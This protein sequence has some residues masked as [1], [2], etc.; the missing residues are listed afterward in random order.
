MT[1]RKTTDHH[2]RQHMAERNENEFTSARQWCRRPVTHS[3]M[4]QMD[5]RDVMCEFSEYHV[6]WPVL[7]RRRRQ[8]GEWGIV[9]LYL[10]ASYIISSV[11]RANQLTHCL[12]LRFDGHLVNGLRSSH[13]PR[14]HLLMIIALN[15]TFCVSLRICIL[16][17]K[18]GHTSRTRVDRAMAFLEFS[19]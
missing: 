17:M 9:F 3:P 5:E 13:L 18:S 15:I 7:G 14:A 12:V 4:S 6:G 1:S 2:R 11:L 10:I 16:R 19:A 8:P